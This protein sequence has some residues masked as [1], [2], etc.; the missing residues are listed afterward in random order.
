MR[1]VDMGIEPYLVAAAINCVIAQR[2]ARRV[3]LACRKAVR[4]PG[5]SVGLSG[6]EVD[7]FEAVGCA[8][9]RH[10]GYRGRI[11]L[12]EVMNVTDEIRAAI[13]ARSVSQDIAR[14]AIAQGMQ[15]LREDGNAK[16]RAGATTLV[17][18]T[19]V[20]G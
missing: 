17:E 16:V 1:L 20:L 2:L 12:Y 18:L 9:C 6:G 14:I 4:V 5:Q 19:R 3:C 15:T 11:G 8:R 7:I 13:V 10:T